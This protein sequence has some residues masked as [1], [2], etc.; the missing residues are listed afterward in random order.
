MP[1]VLPDLPYAYDALEPYIDEQT[2]FIHHTKHHQTYVDK[3]NA[4]LQGRDELL[5]LPVDRLI[6]NLDAVPEGSRKAVRNHGGGHYNHSLFWQT[7]SPDGGGP[8]VGAL[9][10]AIDKS[11]SGFAPFKA[12]FTEA[13]LNNF[14]S[15][16]TFLAVAGGARRL[17]K[18]KQLVI[19][20]TGNQENPLIGA[21]EGM[22]G[23][24]PNTP[25]LGLDLWEHAYYL[26]YQNRRAEYVEAFWNIVNWDEVNRRYAEAQ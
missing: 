11:F 20:N 22:D 2:M 14:G 7:L 16:W 8:A 25:L 3:L 9:M 18:G 4:A 5:D 13:A 10:S 12:Q 26:K 17:P 19:M 24:A 6:Q 23:V 21:N 15:G 1:F